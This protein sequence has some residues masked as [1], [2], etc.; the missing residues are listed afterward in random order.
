MT[1]LHALTEIV[2]ST[3]K[4]TEEKREVFIG[5]VGWEPKAL[6][7]SVTL[8]VDSVYNTA[9]CCP[10]VVEECSFTFVF[11][12]RGKRTITHNQTERGSVQLQP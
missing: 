6:Y 4:M 11:C 12:V 1:D 2:N 10:V 7:F 5:R 9:V 8:S 3:R